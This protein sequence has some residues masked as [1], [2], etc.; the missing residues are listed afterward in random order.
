MNQIIV[1]Y[2]KTGNTEGV[3]N[4]IKDKL[5]VEIKPIKATSDDPNQ[6]SVT[7][8]ETPVIKDYDHVIFGSPVHGF[9]IPKITRAYLTQ[10]DDLTGKTFDLF[11]THHFRFSWLGG[12][13]TLTAMKKLIEE[14][15]G[16][17]KKLTSINWKSKK[18]EE[19]INNMVDRY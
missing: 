7:L 4:L 3:A 5:N 2:S 18:R 6:T 9:M 11:V 17:V 14:K 19:V 1:Y 8:T 10:L 15:N 13:Q 16:I 12:N